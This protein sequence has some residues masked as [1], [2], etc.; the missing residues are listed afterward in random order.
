MNDIKTLIK[1]SIVSL[2]I[3]ILGLFVLCVGTNPKV[4]VDE[5]FIAGG[6][7]EAES[8]EMSDDDFM[9]LL[10][11]AD[12]D[13]SEADDSE[14]AS[15]ALQI[16]DSSTNSDYGDEDLAEILQ[17]LN[18][19]DNSETQDDGDSDEL[20]QLLSEAEGE[21]ESSGTVDATAYKD[22]GEDIEELEKILN[23]KDTQIDSIQQAINKYDEKIAQLEG[24][25]VYPGG[26][27]DNS[28]QYASYTQDEQSAFDLEEGNDFS[29]AATNNE[30]YN[31]ALSYFSNGQYQLATLA[32]QKLLY[33]KPNNELADN[34]QY[35]IGESQFARGNYL[36]AIV[37]FEKVFSFDA[38]DK[39]DDAQI[40]MG[41]ANMR[42]GKTNDARGEFS[43]LLTFYQT[44]EYFDRAQRYINEL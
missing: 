1:S 9:S 5:P 40:M 18:L 22:L 4:N 43:W 24:S 36:Q 41:L 19:D 3:V 31:I 16:D 26:A 38:N 7:V 27:A 25:G 15:E 23:D 12:N 2:I 34:C 30:Q 28:V 8:D 10:E 6:G 33:E 42:A 20:D 13:I 32:F 39:R 17:L 11:S 14:S 44:S 37:E 29:S 21:D 35:W